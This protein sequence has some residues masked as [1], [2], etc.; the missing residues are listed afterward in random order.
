MSITE[1]GIAFLLLVGSPDGYLYPD[2]C[3]VDLAHV[4]PDSRVH[5]QTPK[6]MQRWDRLFPPHPGKRLLGATIIVNPEPGNTFIVIDSSLLPKR[7]YQVLHH[8]RCHVLLGH[9]H[10]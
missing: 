3:L 8:E 10:L 1:F 2:A 5:T 9:W 7:A 4:I 6:Q